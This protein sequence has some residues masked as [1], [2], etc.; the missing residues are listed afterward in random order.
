[1]TPGSAVLP[2]T[3]VFTY[4]NTMSNNIEPRIAPG[5]QT[6]AGGN[7]VVTVLVG[8]DDPA[9]SAF[10]C[11]F[12]GR[13]FTTTIGVGVHIIS[14]HRD[15]ANDRSRSSVKNVMKSGESLL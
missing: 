6:A 1:M 15:G 14:A 10:S 8:V 7:R 12:C 2:R 5:S 4:S 9:T 13:T 11:Q 3:T